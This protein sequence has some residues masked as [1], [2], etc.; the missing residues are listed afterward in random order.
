M[1]KQGNY[2]LFA[3]TNKSQLENFPTML[4]FS[5]ARH[6]KPRVCNSGINNLFKF[7]LSTYKMAIPLCNSKEKA[8]QP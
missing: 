3:K 6:Q 4:S 5:E 1:E 7:S 8:C 2:F